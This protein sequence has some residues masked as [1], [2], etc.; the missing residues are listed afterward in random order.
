[1]RKKIVVAVVGGLI[2][3]VV[4]GLLLSVVSNLGDMFAKVGSWTWSAVSWAWLMVQSSHSM[5]GW[6][7]LIIGLL[8][9]LGFITI[10]ILFRESVQGNKEHPYRNYIEDMVDGV[11]WR[12]RWAGNRIAGL[13]CYCPI[14][15]AQ[16]VYNED[17]YLGTHFICE[18]C[19]SDGSL[20]PTRLRG[21]VVAT[22]SGGDRH[23]AVAAAEREILRRIRTEEH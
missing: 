9:L 10:V 5:P 12:W 8:A 14:C 19:P 16:L 6:A 11:R 3:T 4:G 20:G 18:R 7:I 21:R 15:D 1:M 2:A 23:Y 13:W 17:P 22:V